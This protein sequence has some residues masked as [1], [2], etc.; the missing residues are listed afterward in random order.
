MLSVKNTGGHRH[1]PDSS[2][3]TGDSIVLDGLQFSYGGEGSRNILDGVTFA[4]DHPG[5]YSILG[6]NGVG[7]ST[8][9]HC[10]NKIL[11][12]TGGNVE[13][14]GVPVEEISIKEMAKSVGYVPYSANDSFPLTVVD[15]VM[16][17]RHPYSRWNSLEE[18]LDVVYESLRM[19]GMEDFAMR[20]FNELSAGQHQKI[21]L[22]RGFAQRTKVL[23]LDEPTSNL[24]V[25][26]QLEVTRLLRDLT[27]ERG[28]I[29]VMISH[30]L[31]IAAKYSDMVF[32]IHAGRI[33]AAGTPEEVITEEN[34][35]TV[36]DVDSKVIRVNGKPH[37]ILLDDTDGDVS[38]GV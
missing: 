13:I 8:L 24:D 4:I 30:D 6:P 18:D 21:M 1:V 34:I 9:I 37:V 15:T 36:Y 27:H 26:H 7:K 12:P 2:S 29:V 10:I 14:D 31:N 38:I 35:R 20:P 25:R 32:M 28:M 16:L 19:V 17:G 22:A 11:E 33:Y 3:V 5:F 23:L